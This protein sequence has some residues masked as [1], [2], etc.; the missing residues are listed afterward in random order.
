MDE[1]K[2]KNFFRIALL[3]MILTAGSAGCKSQTSKLPLT[4]DPFEQN[5]LLGRGVNLGNALEAPN[6]GE[7]G[8]TL[9]EV[10]FKLI[11]DKGFD[12]VRIPVRWSAHAALEAPY[13]ID[14]EFFARVDW[15]VNQALQR[16][17]L[18]VLNMHHYLEIF[19]DPDAHRER[20]LA[21]WGQIAEH[22][23]DTS[24]NLIFEL[25]NEPNTNLTPEQW[26]ELLVE[27]LD[28]VRKTNPERNVVIGTAEWGGVSSLFYLKIP[29]ADQHIIVT[30]HYYLPF[31]FT[32][33]GAEWVEGSEAWMGTTWTGQDIEKR[34][35]RTDFQLAQT[36]GE[37][38]QRPIY[39][40][41]F[42]A[43]SK[44]QMEY[45]ALWTEY[46]ARQAEAMGFS[47]AYWEFCAGFGVYD[48]QSKQW[49]EPLVNALIPHKE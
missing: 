2:M 10:Y 7:W 47:W 29:E 36:W 39:L 41:E 18:V 33:Q 22:Y 35:I 12:S 27:G 20:F 37:Q 9:D 44:A 1:Y 6:E 42:G 40:G 32:H 14:P 26:N 48:P 13:T 49:V 21:L 43:Y 16:D 25:L 23:Q 31:H 15:A 34:M 17:L 8:V 38:N 11:K 24:P 19:E 5:K 30:F 28:V 3:L 46:V 4:T 45:R